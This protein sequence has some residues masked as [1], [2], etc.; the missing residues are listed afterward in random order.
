M[1]SKTAD[2]RR[3]GQR[4]EAQMTYIAHGTATGSRLP[5]RSDLTRHRSKRHPTPLDDDLIVR[6]TC[7]R[8]V[9][10]V[11][12]RQVR[13]ERSYRVTDD[14]LQPIDVEIVCVVAPFVNGRVPLPVVVFKP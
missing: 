3:S 10:T 8:P 14:L 4:R 9:R 5:G 13:G 2:A 12:R 11:V 7:T 1:A 6:P